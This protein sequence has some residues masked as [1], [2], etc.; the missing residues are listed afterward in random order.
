MGQA[1]TIAELF[2]YNNSFISIDIYDLAEKN[3]FAPAKLR[4]YK[5]ALYSLFAFYCVI[6]K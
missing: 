4:L 5:Y 2:I 6:K 3:Y 1:L